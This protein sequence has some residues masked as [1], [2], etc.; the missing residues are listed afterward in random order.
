MFI[1]L[2]PITTSIV[3]NFK[4]LSAAQMIFDGN[5]LVIGVLLLINWSYASSGGRLTES[6]TEKQISGVKKEAY[7]IIGI[8]CSAMVLSFFFN[9]WGDF[10]YI[11]LPFSLR[12]L[13]VPGRKNIS[14]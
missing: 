7:V 1:A 9:Y 2:L 10:V 6:L 11:L 4:H 3:N 5:I 12:W 8:S 13:S 14:K